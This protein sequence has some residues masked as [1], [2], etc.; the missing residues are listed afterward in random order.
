MSFFGNFMNN[1]FYGKAGKGDY[2]ISDM[3]QNRRQLFFAVWKVR[4]SSLFG[5]NLLYM[6]FW[7]PT[8]LWTVLNITVLLSAD[9]ESLA[10]PSGLLMSYLLVLAPCIAITGPFTA[11]ATYVMRN[12]ARDEHSFVLSDFFDA[13]KANW[14]Q[15]LP[16]SII[17][18][19]MPLLVYVGWTFYGQLAANSVVFIIP[20]CLLLLVAILWK[21]S[22]MVVYTMMVTYD[23]NLRNLLRNALLMTMAKLPLAIGIK[24]LT[25]VVPALVIAITLLLQTANAQLI[26]LLVLFLLYLLYVPALNRLIIASYANALCEKYLNTKIEGAP[27]NI[28]LR[29]ENWDDTEYIPQD[30]E[31]DA[32]AAERTDKTGDAK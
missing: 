32:S 2:R 19:L 23:L 9:L 12:W 6:V 30:D 24:L 13:V 21:L 17:S 7:L 1:Y 31:D 4:W 5:V 11:G 8:F 10:D 20:M 29:P 28:G 22:E 18:G 27:T 14:K 26:A 3:P 16:V 25:W 15:A